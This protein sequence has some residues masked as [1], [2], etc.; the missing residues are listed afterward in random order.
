MGDTQKYINAG[1]AYLA[2]FGS[3]FVGNDIQVS[4]GNLLDTPVA[5]TLT[6]LAIMY[7]AT[8]NWRIALIVTAAAMFI[9]YLASLSPWGGPYKDKVSA[10]HVD[11]RG[12][13]W[14]QISRGA[15]PATVQIAH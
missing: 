7:Q 12:H 8:Q 6:L 14:P 9:H 4:F 1:V 3:R 11:V 2:F 15:Q 13:F 10:K 5:K